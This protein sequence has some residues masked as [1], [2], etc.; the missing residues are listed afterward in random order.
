MEYI[1]N[2]TSINNIGMGECNN[3]I[4]F[5]VKLDNISEKRKRISIS[6]TANDA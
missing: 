4:F 1:P 5:L 2:M 3:A 6:E